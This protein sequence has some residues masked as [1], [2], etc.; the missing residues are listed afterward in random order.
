MDES[1]YVRIK[2]IVGYVLRQPNL[3]H[4]DREDICQEAAIAAWKHGF[5]PTTRMYWAALDEA[6]RIRKKRVPYLTEYY[7]VKSVHDIEGHVISK[8]VL[9]QLTPLER[10]TVIRTLE[11][12]TQEEI[13]QDIHKNNSTVSRYLASAVKKLRKIYEE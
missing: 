3:T 2:K 11:G 4:C 12:F 8:E 13:A 5:K 7:E 10:Y 6:R 1:E 9:K